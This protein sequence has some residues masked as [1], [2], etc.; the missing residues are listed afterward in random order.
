MLLRVYKC[1]Y[2]VIIWLLRVSE[3]F[4]NMLLGL[5]VLP[6]YLSGFKCVVM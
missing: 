5:Q 3:C 2:H 6:G 4:F 1:F